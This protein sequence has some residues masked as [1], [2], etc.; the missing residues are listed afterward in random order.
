MTSLY[1]SR[2]ALSVS[3]PC[4]YLSRLST[5]FNSSVSESSE[6]FSLLLCSI[7]A[8]TM[9]LTSSSVIIDTFVPGPLL[10]L[11]TAFLIYDSAIS[12]CFFPHCLNRNKAVYSE[13]YCLVIL[14]RK[15]ILL[16]Y[17]V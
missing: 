5:S 8:L 2:Y 4:K 3:I 6:C 7:T 10:N 17:A 13:L 15:F 11:S 12:A 9:I 16:S 1:L 14:L